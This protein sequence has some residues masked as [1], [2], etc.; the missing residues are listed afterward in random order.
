MQKNQLVRFSFHF[1][2]LQMTFSSHFMSS[3]RRASWHLVLSSAPAPS[4]VTINTLH[5]L[6]VSLLQAAPAPPLS[7]V[8][9]K[10]A[11]HPDLNQLGVVALIITAAYM[12]LCLPQIAASLEK[13]LI[14][15]L[16]SSPPDIEA[17][18]LY[19]TLPEC[20]LFSDRNNYVTI[21]IPFAKSL[22][23]L[24]DAALKVLGRRTKTCSGFLP[25]MMQ[26]PVNFMLSSLFTSCL[27]QETGG[28]R[29]SPQS[30]SGWLRCTRRWLCTC[31][32]C[33]RWASLQWSRGSSPVSWTRPCDSWR[34]CTRWEMWENVHGFV[35]PAAS[36]VKFA[37]RITQH[38]DRQLLTIILLMLQV[39]ERAGH[40]IQY[41]KFYIHE[42]D[43]LIDIRNDYVTWIQR[44]MYPPVSLQL[45]D[46]LD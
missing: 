19:L 23:S 16:S 5:H 20:P 35:F 3:F 18:R 21:V 2:L 24:K 44:Q 42:L 22:L 10:Q 36:C 25:H 38:P 45:H 12:F 37:R 41:D 1:S 31:C 7:T 40:I 29:S 39:N 14:P 27:P 15:R 13:N 43:D 46:S 9:M 33:T 4:S 6:I 26:Q 32:G 28:L 11:P 34:S 8:C 17:L 30:F